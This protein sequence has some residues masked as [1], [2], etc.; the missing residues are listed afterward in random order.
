MHTATFMNW[1]GKTFSVDFKAG[2]TRWADL[3]KAAHAAILKAGY[4][5]L[6]LLTVDGDAVEYQLAY[7]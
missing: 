1:N 2:A 4:T 7:R 3:C 5:T 6:Q